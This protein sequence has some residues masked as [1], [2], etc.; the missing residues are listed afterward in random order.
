MIVLALLLCAGNVVAQQAATPR[1][2]TA[3]LYV[4]PP[5]VTEDHGKFSG[6]AVDLWKALAAEL[7]IQ[8]TFRAYSTVRELLDAA[9]RG[10]IEIAVTNLTITQ[11]R[12]LNVDFTQPWFDSG[13]RVMVDQSQTTDFWDIL[14]GLQDSGHLRVYIWFAGIILAGTVLLTL[15]DRRFNP[16]F[17]NKWLDGLA[18]SFF[19]VMSI[20]SGKPTGRKNFFGWVGRVWH[21]LWLFCGIAVLAYVTSS[22][23]SVMTT[24]SLNNQIAGLA[25]LQGKTVGVFAGSVSEDF[26]LSSGFSIRTYPDLEHSVQAL[27]NDEVDAIIGDAEVLEY[28]AHQHPD[29]EVEVV[30][31]LFEPDKYGFALPLRSP[32]TRP[33]TV[34]LL[35]LQENGVVGDLRTKYFGEVK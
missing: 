9:A 12:A 23:A 3:G 27:Q 25:D 4:N 30:G 2:V 21:G 34:E 11:N 14:D 31:A 13:Q 33:L 16:E 1:T 18:E 6:M 20:A 24:L 10:E 28:Y 5:F 17:P 19:A 32:L 7:G 22:I 29:K 26:A 15:F 8:T 35:G